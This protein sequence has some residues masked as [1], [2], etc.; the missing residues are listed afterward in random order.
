MT[1]LRRNQSSILEGNVGGGTGMICHQFKGGI[2]T[3]SREVVLN[4]SSYL[5][6]TL[7][8][9]NYGRREDLTINGINVGEQL[10]DQLPE[11][12]TDYIAGDGSIIVIVATPSTKQAINTLKPRKPFR[13]SR[14][15]SCQEIGSTRRFF[16]G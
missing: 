12:N 13:I 3:S 2:G 11:V 1:F 9:A 6:G 8:Q 16:M 7:V 15:A 10:I 14:L 5:V 4:N